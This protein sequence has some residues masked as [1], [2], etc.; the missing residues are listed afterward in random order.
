MC[1]E[2]VGICLLAQHKNTAEDG[3]KGDTHSFGQ[4]F[5]LAELKSRLSTQVIFSIEKEKRKPLKMTRKK[6]VIFSWILT[7]D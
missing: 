1:V 5:P 4:V 2:V 7:V 3:G 6:P